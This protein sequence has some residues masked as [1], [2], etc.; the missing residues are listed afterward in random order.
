MSATD[1]QTTNRI[2]IDELGRGNLLPSQFVGRFGQ[3]T[4]E[5]RFPWFFGLLLAAATNPNPGAC[6]VVLDKT[7]AA[8]FL[9]WTFSNLCDLIGI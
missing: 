4:Q 3:E 6:C 1:S 2:L 8:Q 9:Y 7:Q 5:E